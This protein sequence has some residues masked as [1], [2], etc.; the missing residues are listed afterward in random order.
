MIPSYFKRLEIPPAKTTSE[1]IDQLKY[2]I[3]KARVE[4][5]F[6]DWIES[7]DI[8]TDSWTIHYPDGGM[9]SIGEPTF[10]CIVGN[11][12]I[13]EESLEKTEKWLWDNFSAA[14]YALDEKPRRFSTN[15]SLDAGFCLHNMPLSEDCLD[16]E[17]MI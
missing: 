14:H 6:K 8:N 4:Y 10:T 15:K 7:R 17:A 5:R 2:E 16:C 12:E 13:Q 9:I 1:R 3:D 11:Q